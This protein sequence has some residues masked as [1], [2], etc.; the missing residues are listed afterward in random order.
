MRLRMWPEST[1]VPAF[2]AGG[3][4]ARASGTVKQ[5]MLKLAAAY[6]VNTPFYLVMDSDV[7]ARRPWSASD[8]LVRGRGTG[9][10]SLRAR[11]GL[12]TEDGRFVQ[13]PSWLRESARALRT[14]LIDATDA[15]CSAS[16]ARAGPWFAKSAGAAMPSE[17]PFALLSS[18]GSATAP[19][20]GVCNFGRARATH[21]TPMVLAAAVVREILV[22][23]LEAG[24]TLSA[25]GASGSQPWVSALLAYHS[26]REDACWARV[27]PGMGGRFY[28]WTEY[29]LYFAAAVASGAMDQY[30][31]FAAGGITSLR[32]SMMLPSEYEAADWP[33]IFAD[34]ATDDAPFF[35][36]HSW[37]G[38]PVQR[39]EALLAPHVAG[40]LR[41]G[42][43]DDAQPSPLPLY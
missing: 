40:L 29:G 32:R 28:S 27:L 16:G 25:G 22:P 10:G 14:G 39:T 15:Y 34:D 35:I 26:S 23:R 42:D 5:M 12:D 36:V 33:A 2:A 43:V 20:F 31:T 8:L 13:E 6:I 38:K 4:G 30:H 21:V 1:V 18:S 17:A 7:Y 3:A 41:P 11:T 9:A 37:F 19:T 24:V